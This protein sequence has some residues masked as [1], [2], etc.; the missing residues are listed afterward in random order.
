MTSQGRPI[1]GGAVSASA[2]VASPVLVGRDDQLTR[3]GRRIEETAAGSGGLLFLAGE[4]GIGKTRLIGSITRRAERAGFSIVRAAAFPG[5]SEA[6]GGVLLDLAGDLTRSPHEDDREVGRAIA[7]RLTQPEPGEQE[8]PRRR[9]LLVQDL[10]DLLAGLDPDRALLVVLEDLHWADELSLDVLD[11][12]ASRLPHRATLMV[13]AYR[14]DELY[15]RTPTRQWRSRLVSSRLAEEFRLP[16]LSL[17]QTAQLI[18]AVLGRAAPGDVVSGIQDRSDGIPLHVEELLAGAGAGALEGDVDVAGVAVPETLA[19]AVL[20]RIGRHDDRTRDVAAAAAVIGRSFDFDLLTA[21]LQDD[22]GLVERSLRELQAA[23][24]VQAGAGVAAF[25]FRHALIRDAVYSDV[26][27]PR[28]RQLHERVARVAAERGYPDAFLSAHFEQAGL[29]AQS[30][31]HAVAAAREAVGL[32]AH[33]EALTLYRRALRNAPPDLPAAQRAALLAAVGDEAAA[34][35]DNAAAATAYLAAHRLW[36]ESGDAVAAAAVVPARVAVAHLLGEGLE[37]RARLLDEALRSVVGIEGAD[38]VRGLLLGALAAAYMLD[39]RLDESLAYG[40]Q[41]RALSD[42]VGDER[43]SLDTAATVGS[44]LLFAGRTAE[45]WATLEQAIER[46]TELRYEGGAARGYRMLGSSASVLVD[47][48]R[49]EPWLDRGIAYADAVEQWNHR[50]YLAAHLA[51][52]QW[53]CGRWADAERTAEHALADGRG[54]VTTLITARYVAGY[55]ALGRGDW[56]A[57]REHLDDALRRGESMTELQRLSP[58]LWGLA[59]TA[60]LSGELDEAVALCERG[61][62]A[63]RRVGDAA[64]LFPFVLT[65]VRSLLALDRVD[66]AHEFF[67]RTEQALRLRSIPG[68]LPVLAHARGLLCFAT[69]DVEAAREHLSEAGTEWSR[70]RRFWEGNW[71]RLDLARCAIR[72]RALAEAGCL[73]GEVRTA[74]GEAGASVLVAAADELLRGDRGSRPADPWAPL[75]AREFTVAGLVAAGLTNREIAARLVLSPKTV[76]AHVEHILAKLGMAR[77]SQ[78]AAWT[79]TVVPTT[80]P[81]P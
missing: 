65:G 70:L 71:A 14:S 6:S 2:V 47:Y 39:R 4:A 13:G 48:D 43:T 1:S 55:L 56:T 44:V 32:S 81:A 78:I 72:T 80:A 8:A 7:E 36:S 30:H 41:S 5:D 20:L 10:A 58:P 45:G 3:A 35:D 62:A 16:R 34:T 74:A 38:R 28:R 50:N 25:D 52:V 54:G 9:R 64:Y 77:R 40:E 51:H 76:S 46:A 11:R 26:S 61:L 21:V 68:T 31:R 23:H 66:G 17:D 29:R 22:G 42:A 73:A 59:E 12:L 33:R 24:L 18:S 75:T 53:A 19:D 63:S 15:P 27:L 37:P 67:A 79:A 69:G 57:A 60:R 49:A